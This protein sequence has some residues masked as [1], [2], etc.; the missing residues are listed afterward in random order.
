MASLIKIPRS[1]YWYVCF[2]DPLTRKRMRK[3][4]P[5]RWNDRLQTRA[6]RELVAKKTYEEKQAPRTVAQEQW[7]AWVRPYLAQRYDDREKT[8]ERFLSAWRTIESFLI[9]HR[10]ETPAQLNHQG[11]AQYIAWRKQ[12]RTTKPIA[13]GTILID[14]KILRTVMDEAMRRG[15]ATVNPCVR[16]GISRKPVHETR[17][18][19]DTEDEI[20]RR[21]LRSAPEWMQVSYAIA[22]AQGCRFSETRVRL[23]DI[24][25]RRGTILFHA[26]GGKVFETSLTPSLF[27]L[28]QRLEQC[29]ATWTWDLPADAMLQTGRNWTRF[30]RCLGLRHLHFHCTRVT[31]IT[32]AHRRGVSL[33]K[34]LRFFGHKSL[35]HWVYLRLGAEDVSEVASALASYPSFASFNVD[36]YDRTNQPLVSSQ[37]PGR[38]IGSSS[39]KF[40]AKTRR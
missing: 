35:V 6:A 23:S 31:A 34:A 24:D 25:L 33:A 30:F 38:Q 22:M 12:S 11:V 37:A 40:T 27:P 26:K 4:T 13:A 21:A 16:L 10:I 14:T 8:R 28:I 9:G 1:P 2:R 32:R 36:E 29:R 18:I 39:N 17:E 7:T 3:P 15:W 19:K 20:I 5:C